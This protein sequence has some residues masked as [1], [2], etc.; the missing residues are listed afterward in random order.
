MAY[1]P[2]KHNR[3]SIRLKGYDY[4]QAGLYFVTICV[5]HRRCLFGEIQN[6]QLH[7]NPAGKMIEKWYAELEKKFPDIQCHEKIIMPNHIHFIVENVGMPARTQIHKNTNT[8]PPVRAD[9]RVCPNEKPEID[10]TDSELDETHFQL[11]ER[12]NILTKQ[13]DILHDKNLNLNE[14]NSNLNK[15]NPLLNEHIPISNEH[16]PIL[17]EHIPILGEHTGSP[18][19]RVVQWFK[20]MSTNEYIRRVKSDKWKRFDGKLWQRNYY[21]HIIRN[22]TAHQNISNYI[23]N[24]PKNWNT[25]KLHS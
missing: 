17:N 6:G 11:D 20:T 5:Q 24:N 1:D 23:V 18:L 21:E 8:I 14:R 22:E 12:K 7:L 15:N 25:D 13:N 3:K 19:H 2:N 9:L 4:A 10:S 16:I